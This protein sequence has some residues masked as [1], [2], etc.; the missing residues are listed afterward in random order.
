MHHRRILP[1]MHRTRN[2]PRHQLG[3]TFG[4]CPRAVVHVPVERFGQQHALSGRQPDAMHVV[5]QEQQAGDLLA[6]LLQA[7]LGRL[8]DAVHRVVAAV[9]EADDLGAAGLGLHQIGREIGRAGE[10]RQRL[11]QHLAVRRRDEAGGVAFQRMTEGVVGGD[12]EPGVAAFLHRRIDHAV[13]HRPGVVHPV[14]MVRTAMRAGDVGR[15]AAGEDR[16]L[17]LRLHHVADGERRRGQ[18]H[19]GDQI[20]ALVVQ[21][22][23]G[24]GDRDI[25]LQL[26][27]GGDQFHLQIGMQFGE[28][29]DRQL[30]AGDRSRAGIGGV[31]TDHVG[32]HADA[33]RLR[34]CPRGTGQRGDWP[35]RR[36][37]VGDAMAMRS[38][39]PPSFL[40]W[41]A[42]AGSADFASIKRPVNIAVHRPLVS[43]QIGRWRSD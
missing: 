24:D 3:E 37:A 19:I 28:I 27:I 9:G 22:V 10:W 15:G 6:A 5:D 25:G 29:L 30:R 18:R 2:V 31:D 35:S 11:A 1:G 38:L 16:R 12:E 32:Q 17:V 34:L 26:Q 21:P 7:E 4:E 42:S 20:D 43:K 33:D 40:Y 14:Q 39:L 8:L 41:A 13:R 36:Q 23:A